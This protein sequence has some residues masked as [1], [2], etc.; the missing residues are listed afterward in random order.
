MFLLRDNIDE[1]IQLLSLGKTICYPTDA[2]W[3]IGGDATRE[4]TANKIH[5][6]KAN[7]HHEPFVILVSD[8]Q[9]LQAVVPHLHPRIQTLLDYH[10]RPLTILYEK[11]SLLCPNVKA[12][13]GSAAV[14]VATDPFCQLLI[15]KFGKPLI[16]T[17][18]AKNNQP[19]PQ[20][21]GSISSD[22]LSAVDYV[23]KYRQ[24]DKEPRECSTIA[25]LNADLE[26][27]F[28]RS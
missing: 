11:T 26:L 3:A 10:Q 14:R 6:I 19:P 5:E 21:F 7:K 8:L 17:I 22:I 23:V 12:A 20:T 1:I 2:V 13:D 25:K 16:A 27:Q 24:D 4:D 9:M 15:G 18:A 28:L